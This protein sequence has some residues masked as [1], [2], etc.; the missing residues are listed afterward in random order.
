LPQG[1]S[2]HKFSL[3]DDN[4]YPTKKEIIFHLIIWSIIFEGIGPL[5]Y[6]RATVDI[7]DVVVYW[8]GGVLSWTIWNWK[9]LPSVNFP[10]NLY[11]SVGKIIIN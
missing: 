1:K 7:W 4:G 5:L 11:F 6:S 10:K 2:Q 9:S 8:L 3:R